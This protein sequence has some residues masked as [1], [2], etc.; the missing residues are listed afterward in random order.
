[1]KKRKCF[2]FP[3]PPSRSLVRVGQSVG[4]PPVLTCGESKQ[5]TTWGEQR[6]GSFARRLRRGRDARE[7]LVRRSKRHWVITREFCEARGR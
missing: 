2:F 6:A 3:P 5:T 4:R 7:R 1:M